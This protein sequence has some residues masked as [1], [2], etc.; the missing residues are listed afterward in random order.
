MTVNGKEAQLSPTEY[1]LLKE[2]THNAGKVLDHNY[3]LRR[4]WGPGYQDEK[5]HVHLYI[6]YLRRKIEL[7]P[8]KPEYIMTVSKIGYVF[9]H[10]ENTLS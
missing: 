8:A 9:K 6:R 2:L 7:N 10:K 3:L 5:Q 4:I 1:A